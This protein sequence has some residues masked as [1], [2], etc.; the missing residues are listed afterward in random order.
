MSMTD[1]LGTVGHTTYAY[2]AAHRITTITRSLGGTEKTWLKFGYDNA[3]RRTSIERTIGGSGTKILTTLA[4]DNA[5]RLTTIQH[6]VSGGSAL[7]TY[8]YGFNSGGLITTETNAEGLASYSYDDTN[9]LTGVDRP[10]G[11]TDESYGYDLNGNR[12]TTGYTTTTGNRMT[13]SPGYTYTYDAEGNTSAKTETGTSKVTTYGYDHR[14]RLTGVTQKNGGGSVIMQATCV[15]DALGR[16]IKTDVDADGA[17][18]GAATVTWSMYDGQNTYADFN[19]GG[20]LTMRYL[21]GLAIDELFARMDSG[22]TVA[23][24]LTDHLG[25]VRDIVDTS[26]SSVYHASY[27]AFGTIVSETGSGGDRFA[28]TGREWDS[29]IRLQ[30]NRNRYLDASTGRWTTIDPLGL[31]AGDSNTFR[32]AGNAPIQFDD[33]LGLFH[34]RWDDDPVVG[35]DA[36]PLNQFWEYVFY[37]GPES[38]Y[39]REVKR[40]SEQYSQQVTDINRYYIVKH[41]PDEETAKQRIE[42]F[43]SAAR[44]AFGMALVMKRFGQEKAKRIGDIHEN[45]YYMTRDSA[46]DQYNNDQARKLVQELGLLTNNFEHFEQL[47]VE[48]R[49]TAEIAAEFIKGIEDQ[50]K[51]RFMFDKSHRDFWEAVRLEQE[52]QMREN[53]YKPPQYTSTNQRQSSS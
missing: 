42:S 25:T 14:N 19:S 39:L 53:G 47:D 11:Q 1:S 48:V 21:H 41:S 34:L 17:G 33:P 3:D 49:F 9:Q 2:D 10:T 30:Y 8:V 40:K 20:T 28:F 37:L 50:N 44:H 31:Q 36:N 43:K 15:Y 18:G 7:A 5:S 24:Y 51:G 16:R 52:R 26:G 35:G 12:N 45:H 32:Y 46:M 22:G 27:E 4:Y 38:Y 6:A 29:A 13:A 23:W